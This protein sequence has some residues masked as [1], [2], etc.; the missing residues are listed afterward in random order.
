MNKQFWVDHYKV[1]ERCSGLMKV[2]ESSTSRA[3]RCG[4]LSRIVY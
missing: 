4:L 1:K 2:T 3:I